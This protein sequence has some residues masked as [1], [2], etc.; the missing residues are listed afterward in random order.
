[1]CLLARYVM[2]GVK[3]SREE[4]LVGALGGDHT[5]WDGRVWDFW[6]VILE[7]RIGLALHVCDPRHV[8]SVVGV[9]VRSKFNWCGQ[10]GH[11]LY[12]EEMCSHPPTINYRPRNGASEN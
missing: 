3:D 2:E 6:P 12:W 11:V 5:V 7:V 10:K 4:R 9:Q 1:M 8:F